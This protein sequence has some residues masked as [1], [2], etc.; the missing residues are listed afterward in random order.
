MNSKSEIQLALKITTAA[1]IILIAI[2][3]IIITS[4]FYASREWAYREF[5]EKVKMFTEWPRI[6]NEVTKWDIGTMPWFIKKRSWPRD[7]VIIDDDGNIIKNEL[8]DFTHNDIISLLRSENGRIDIKEIWEVSFLTY[9]QQIWGYSIF[10]FE[11]MERVY[12]FHFRLAII[13]FLWSIIGFV[14]IFFLSRYL[15]RLTIRPIQEH[16]KELESYSHNVAHELRTPLSVMRSNLELL[17]IKPENRFIQSTDDEI[18]NMEHIIESLLFLAKPT[19]NTNE[20][21]KIDIIKITEECIE[22]YKLQEDIQWE[23]W[24]NQIKESIDGELYKRMF[25]NLIENAI[26]YK[27]GWSILVEIKDTVLSIKNTIEKE[28]PEEEL[29]KLTKSF[30]Q[31]DTSRNTEWYWLWLALVEKITKIFGWKM[32]ISCTKNTFSVEIKMK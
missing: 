18:S 14:I 3:S 17:R 24:N 5:N 28:I 15:A 12:D 1:S 4:S 13:A 22:K 32:H 9:R 30:Y 8:F 2:L 21:K 31:R 25:T 19:R 6:L 26:K 29:L 23:K 10:I 11:D 7:I 16:N 20:N 27:S